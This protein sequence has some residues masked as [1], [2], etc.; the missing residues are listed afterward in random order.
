MCAWGEARAAGL[1]SLVHHKQSV[2]YISTTIKTS[3]PAFTATSSK[4]RQI[5]TYSIGLAILV[6][7]CCSIKKKKKKTHISASKSLKV[8]LKNKHFFSSE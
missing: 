2:N 1:K 3:R 7:L 5:G 6:K 8:V 4:D